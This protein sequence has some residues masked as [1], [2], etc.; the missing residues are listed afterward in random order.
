VFYAQIAPFMDFEF[1]ITGLKLKVKGNDSSTQVADLQRQVQ[2]LMATITSLAQGQL[3]TPPQ[4]QENGTAA[5]LLEGAQQIPQLPA[6]PNGT[7]V[8]TRRTPAARRGTASGPRQ[9]AE[10]IDFK[11]D[12]DQYG[13]PRQNWA[14]A[15]KA[16]WTIYVLAEQGDTKEFSASVIA[17]TFNK[18]FKSFGTILAQ[19]VLRDLGKEKGKSGSVN[20]DASQEPMKWYLLEAGKKMIPA[21]VEEAKQ[22]AQ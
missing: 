21:L 9:R 3:Q 17:A 2:G 14:T 19:N 13:F 22:P 20:S 11:H 8:A 10:A 15:Q 1:E 4:I 5:N 16:M 18:H 12:A 6:P 7:R